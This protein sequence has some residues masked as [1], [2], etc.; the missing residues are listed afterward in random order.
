M[1]G[2]LIGLDESLG[3]FFSY[4]LLCHSKN[5]LSHFRGAKQDVNILASVTI[6]VICD[7]LRCDYYE[8]RQYLVFKKK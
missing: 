6:L 7:D 5:I 3:F 8:L 4:K 1:L 2:E